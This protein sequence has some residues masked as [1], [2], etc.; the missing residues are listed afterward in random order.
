MKHQFLKKKDNNDTLQIGN[1][2][3]ILRNDIFYTREELKQFES[4]YQEIIKQI[5]ISHEISL[6]NKIKK[7][8]NILYINQQQLNQKPIYDSIEFK[9]MLET[10]DA[11]LIRFFD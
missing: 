10:A 3:Y 1:H 2:T 8:S 6:S 9:N 11:D 4:D 7:M 5:T